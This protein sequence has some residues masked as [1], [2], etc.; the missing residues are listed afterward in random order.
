MYQGNVPG[1]GA[2]TVEAFFHFLA[3]AAILVALII[4]FKRAL[5]FWI[6]I[7]LFAIGVGYELYEFIARLP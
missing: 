4:V 5:P 6:A 3:A 1:R 2:M 7:V